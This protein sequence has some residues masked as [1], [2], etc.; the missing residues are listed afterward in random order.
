MAKERIRRAPQ[1]SQLFRSIFECSKAIW[2][3]SAAGYI[4]EASTIMTIIDEKGRYL[5]WEDICNRTNNK[6]KALGYWSLIKLAR[7]GASQ[8]MFGLQ[9]V[10]H[11]PS[12]YC[13][14]PAIQKTCSLI[15]RTCTAVA[16]KALIS[17]SDMEE[18]VFSDF[19]DDE[20]I[21][22][23]QLEGAATTK[24][25]ALEIL[26][27]G[28][29]PKSES[30][31]MILGNNRLMN[32]AWETR[33]DAMTEE[34]FLLFHE[35]ASRGVNDTTYSPGELRKDNSVVVADL[36]GNTIHQPPDVSEL[37]ESVKA[38][39]K[40]ININHEDDVSPKR[41]IHPVVKTCIIHFCV[42]YLHPFND[43]NG[44][45]ARA[46]SYWYLFRKGY[47]AFRYISIS[48]LL[49]EA[50][51][52]YAE[53]Y[54]KTE[55]DGLDLTYFVEYQCRILERAINGTISKVTDAVTQARQFNL[56]LLTS[57]VSRKL[58]TI[59]QYIIQSVIIE[60]GKTFTV[61][62]LEEGAGISES[63][64]R[65]NLERMTDVGMLNRT[66]GGGNKP[67]TY[68]GK[69]SINDIKKAIIKLTE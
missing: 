27:E 55:R 14:L 33:H 22:S 15:D 31:K 58:T 28:R 43:G 69:K 46:L 2:G 59:Q 30:D 8:S 10:F 20:S 52:Q 64:A 47:D 16:I 23:S 45:V 48:R 49:K 54:M 6:E 3:D 41:Y 1:G 60:S 26:R 11:K 42:G 32:L 25:V 66:G 37:H 57:G 29:T 13:P 12:F 56:W 19:I 40:W 38:F 65:K 5:H 7:N 9:D 35:T 61:R 24:K 67:V 68:T 44:R 39:I 21:A 36:E 50:P 4:A 63:A 18:S 17:S 62:Q 34:L 51:I 53:A